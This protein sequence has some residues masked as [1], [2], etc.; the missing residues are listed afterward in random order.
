M[1]LFAVCFNIIVSTF[2]L[3]SVVTA[4]QFAPT[5]MPLKEEECHAGMT[6]L[7]IRRGNCPITSSP[8]SVPLKEVSACLV[9]QEE[10]ARDALVEPCY[11]VA[12]VKCI[13]FSSRGLE[14]IPSTHMRAHNF[15]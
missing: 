14:P 4:P 6:L 10:G 11:S 12:T 5:T 7:C 9:L 2:S 8:Q 3:V 1:F 13:C 15:L